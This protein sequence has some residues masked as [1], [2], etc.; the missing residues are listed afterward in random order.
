[1]SALSFGTKV[2]RD[3]PMT[4][5]LAGVGL[6]IATS[7]P[8]EGALAGTQQMLMGDRDAARKFMGAKIE[9]TIDDL[10]GN[11]A[12]NRAVARLNNNHLYP[13]NNNNLQ[14]PSGNIVFGAYNTRMR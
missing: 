3:R 1:M 9:T 8:F 7:N 12:H 4:A 13:R 2:I 14:G 5:M 10:Q 6:G 11:S